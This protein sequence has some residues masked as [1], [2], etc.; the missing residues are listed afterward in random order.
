MQIHKDIS[1]FYSIRE[2]KSNTINQNQEATLIKCVNSNGKLNGG[3]IPAFT[4]TVTNTVVCPIGGWC[5]DKTNQDILNI[6]NNNLLIDNKD[7]TYKINP[8]TIKP[9]NTV[10]YGL[11]TPDPTTSISDLCQNA[12]PE[13]PVECPAEQ[14]AG[15]DFIYKNCVDA[16]NDNKYISDLNCN[17]DNCTNQLQREI[18]LYK[19]NN[20]INVKCPKTDPENKDTYLQA[21]SVGYESRGDYKPFS[22]I[23]PI[24]GYCQQN[25][26]LLELVDLTD[27]K[28]RSEY[29]KIK[30]DENG[31]YYIP[32]DFS[33]ISPTDGTQISINDSISAPKVMVSSLCS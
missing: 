29:S 8:F 22:F 1:A 18:I 16:V 23:C 20:L 10:K 30:K 14:L 17:S 3:T 13:P 21:Y 6:S 31:N 33:L 5:D 15:S 4:Y 24:G 25:L 2:N 26:N 7:G 9:L 19:S 11:E 28:E 32:N 12:H 27:D